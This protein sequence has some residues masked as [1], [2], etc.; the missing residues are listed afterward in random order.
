MNSDTILP[1]NF[2]DSPC[3]PG[4]FTTNHRNGLLKIIH[5][6]NNEHKAIIQRIGCKNIWFVKRQLG[7]NI[8]YRNNYTQWFGEK[9]K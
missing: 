2:T 4:I 3:K 1:D 8:K 6:K 7:V 9:F 5:L